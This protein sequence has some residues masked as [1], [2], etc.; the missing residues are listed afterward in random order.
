[1]NTR[2]AWILAVSVVTCSCGERGRQPTA[3]VQDGGLDG[4]ARTDASRDAPADAIRREDGR[5]YDALAVPDA[6]GTGD[7]GATPFR[8]AIGA[9]TGFSSQSNVALGLA[10]LANGDLIVAGT[11]G[12]SPDPA[13]VRLTSAGKVAWISEIQISTMGQ[14]AQ[15]P[16]VV[17]PTAGS[18]DVLVVGSNPSDYSSFVIKVSGDGNIVGARRW[19]HLTCRVAAT[20]KDG[21]CVGCDVAIPGAAT[22]DQVVLRVDASGQLLWSRRI[23]TGGS[24]YVGGAAIVGDS[25]LVVGN[26][27]TYDPRGEPDGTAAL[28]SD[29]GTLRWYRAYG[30]RDGTSEAAVAAIGF[31]NGTGLI[32]LEVPPEDPQGRDG[33]TTLLVSVADTGEVRWARHYR[34]S[35]VPQ[36]E[37]GGTPC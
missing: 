11:S 33:W 3:P 16:W 19:E 28:F 27:R 23:S 31:A 18:E 24:A 34:Y 9:S 1:M 10:S 30:R 4:D 5:L 14:A 26:T 6:G 36:L 20:M 22:T 13:V 35:D 2:R 12:V 32:S 29:D 15:K 7:G 25:C 17:L 21:L 8:L 37:T